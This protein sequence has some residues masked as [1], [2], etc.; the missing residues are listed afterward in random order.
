MSLLGCAGF[1]PP[2]FLIAACAFQPM[3]SASI[4]A[5]ILLNQA[6]TA[7]KFQAICR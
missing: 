2:I 7:I 1:G 4:D 5:E 3:I 6:L